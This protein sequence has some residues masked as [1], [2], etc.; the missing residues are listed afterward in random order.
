MNKVNRLELRCIQ[1]DNDTQRYD[2]NFYVDG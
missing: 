2:F 1:Y